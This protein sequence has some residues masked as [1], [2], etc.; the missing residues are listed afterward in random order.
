MMIVTL[1]F[2]VLIP[3]GSV[4]HIDMPKVSFFICIC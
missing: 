1:A 4:I 3:I 2:P